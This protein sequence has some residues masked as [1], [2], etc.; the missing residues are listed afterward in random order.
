[1]MGRTEIDD[2]WELTPPIAGLQP[3]SSLNVLVTVKVQQ[4]TPFLDEKPLSLACSSGVTTAC[5]LQQ[6][7]LQDCQIVNV[8][9]TPGIIT[10]DLS[11]MRH[12][13]ALFWL[14]SEFI[15]CCTDELFTEMK[16]S[17]DIRFFHLLNY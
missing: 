15:V 9:D 12:F 10:I 16:M 5:E 8:I 3:W 7:V 2:D 4:A 17:A 14:L 11:Y 1:M 6:T 13:E